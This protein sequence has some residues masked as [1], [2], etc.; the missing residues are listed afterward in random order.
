[1]NKVFLIFAL[2]FLI[3]CSEENSSNSSKNE[4]VE[5]LY[6]NV[7]SESFDK[8]YGIFG[9]DNY[10]GMIYLKDGSLYTK[11]DVIWEVCC[12][13]LEDEIVDSGYGQI[14]YL[15]YKIKVAQFFKDTY[16][17]VVYYGVEKGL[18]KYLCFYDKLGKFLNK[19]S[20]IK[21]KDYRIVSC[22]WNNEKIIIKNEIE[23]KFHVFDKN[24]N[25][26]KY[27]YAGKNNIEYMEWVNIEN[28]YYFAYST[29]SVGFL[30]LRDKEI[31]EKK[32]LNIEEYVEILYPNEKNT[33]KINKVV[34][35][36]VNKE[37]CKVEL[38]VI[39]FNS[40]KEIVTIIL[41]SN[42]GEIITPNQITQ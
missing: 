19:S 18:C 4:D 39:L 41:N 7:L 40:Q 38:E 15:P 22:P 12:D 30:L 23:N 11:D 13:V 5:F 31:E 2:L 8:K 42:T 17:I 27:V 20:K 33:P 26:E 28:N 1:M 32:I 21:N 16:N 3:G 14:E 25:E 36:E 37:R 9:G 24:G 29:Q 34:A 10:L 6:I 35:Y